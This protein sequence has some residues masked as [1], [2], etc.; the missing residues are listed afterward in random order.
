MRMLLAVMI[1]VAELRSSRQASEVDCM[2]C[3]ILHLVV[4]EL[5]DKQISTVL[6]CKGE[7]K[8]MCSVNNDAA[9]V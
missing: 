9:S 2:R 5:S 4:V 3:A 8:Q 1:D 6:T 7:S